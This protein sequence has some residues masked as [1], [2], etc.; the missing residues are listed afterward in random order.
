MGAG[1]YRARECATIGQMGHT[2]AEDEGKWAG[3]WVGVIGRV[4]KR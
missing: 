1:R 4:R 3:W 2:G